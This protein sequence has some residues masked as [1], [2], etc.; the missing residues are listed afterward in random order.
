MKR[1]VFDTNAFLRLFLNDIPEQANLVENLLKKAKNAE[2]TIYL[3]QIIIFEIAYALDKYYNF[4]KDEVIQKLK[5]IIVSPYLKVQ[6]REVFKETVKTY[7]NQ[8]ISLPDCFISQFAEYKNCE[9]F[10]FDKKLKK[11]TK[12]S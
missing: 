4:P 12:N 1:Y 5:S 2:V 6:N 7:K 3:P 11:I 10:T 8:T 9:I